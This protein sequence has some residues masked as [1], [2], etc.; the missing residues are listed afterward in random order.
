MR[1]GE[2]AR[3]TGLSIDTLRFYEDQ[4]VIPPPPRLRNGY[5]D[6]PEHYVTL[7]GF[8]Q[9]ARVLGIPLRRTAE[10]LAALADGATADDLRAVVQERH[11]ETVATITRL[12]RLRDQLGALLEV[13]DADVD[14]FVASFA[15]DGRDL[16]APAPPGETGGPAPVD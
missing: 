3:A 11:D 10:V 8:V 2:L 12:T 13:P 16:D 4:G 15:W 7:L 1:R 14:R 9:E 6:Y 5:R